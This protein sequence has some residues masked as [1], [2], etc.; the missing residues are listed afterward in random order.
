M[1]KEIPFLP[2]KSA[3]KNASLR[4]EVSGAE[5]PAMTFWLLEGEGYGV[6][7]YQAAMA[8]HCAAQIR[9]WLSAAT[10]AR[11][12]CGRGNRQI[13]LKPLILPCWCAVVRKRR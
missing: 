12:C 5:Q 10:A 8:Q 6:A 1:F 11:R 3:P 2:V 9:D 13:L 4:F 7:D